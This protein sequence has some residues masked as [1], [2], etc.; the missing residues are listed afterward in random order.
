M[1]GHKRDCISWNFYN[2]RVRPFLGLR[3]WYQTLSKIL[4]PLAQ[5]IGDLNDAG[6]LRCYLL[7][8]TDLRFVCEE[9]PDV[10]PFPASAF[11][12]VRLT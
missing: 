3:H 11:L 10:R 9:A 4:S 5:W 12:P 1:N 7:K 6:E 8:E 2:E